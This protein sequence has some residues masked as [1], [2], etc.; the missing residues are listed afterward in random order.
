MKCPKELRDQCMEHIPLTCNRCYEC[1]TKSYQ[2]CRHCSMAF[3]DKKLFESI[4]NT[5]NI[6]K[7]L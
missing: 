3:K 2:L 4:I 6:S 1:K 5:Y 7:E